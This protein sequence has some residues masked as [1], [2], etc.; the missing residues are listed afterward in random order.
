MSLSRT[1]K[2]AVKAIWAKM[3]KSIDVI[4]AEAFG[5]M[6]IAYPQ[7]KIYFSEWSDLRP[8][9]GPVKAHGKKV[10]GGIATAVASIDDL[11]CGL[12]ELS[13][14]H[15]F[16]LKVDPANF[17]L[18]AHCILVVTAIMFPKDFTPEI[19]VSFDKFLAGVALALSDKY[20]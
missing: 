12:R 18:L 8:A 4:G 16:T 15:A 11:T 13:E 7:T 3:S 5:R 2:E 14:R 9:S 1:D 17:R 20:R 10:M 19:H 6:L